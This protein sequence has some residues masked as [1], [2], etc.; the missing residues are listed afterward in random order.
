MA[1]FSFIS[2]KVRS[3]PAAY[4]HIGAVMVLT[5]GDEVTGAGQDWLGVDRSGLA[6]F[7]LRRMGNGR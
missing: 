1:Q 4:P 5:P 7:G 3:S 6:P 2:D